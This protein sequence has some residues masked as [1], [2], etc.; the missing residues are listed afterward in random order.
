MNNKIERK[1]YGI[2][3]KYLEDL[4]CRMAIEEYRKKYNDDNGEIFNE[5][6]DKNRTDF[7]EQIA[8]MSC[9]DL[10]SKWMMLIMGCENEYGEEGSYV[11]KVL[12]VIKFSYG[13]DLTD[14]EFKTNEKREIISD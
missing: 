8:N 10:F 3:K 5:K 4:R 2:P 7:D 12:E 14:E 6:R 1:N 11:E 13:I 9:R